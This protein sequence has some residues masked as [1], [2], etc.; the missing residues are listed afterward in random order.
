MSTGL[1][2]LPPITSPANHQRLEQIRLANLKRAYQLGGD[3]EPLVITLGYNITWQ[4]T[5][6]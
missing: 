2:S 1:K 6:E 5:I 4:R 3:Q